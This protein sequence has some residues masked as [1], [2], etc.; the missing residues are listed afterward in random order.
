MKR[1]R[2]R[3]P[4]HENMQGKFLNEIVP[5]PNLPRNSDFEIVPS[6]RFVVAFC[7]LGVT[8]YYGILNSG[9]LIVEQRSQRERRKREPRENAKGDVVEEQRSSQV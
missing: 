3:N 9:A 6:W 7:G 2:T 5:R 1:D 8:G 4:K